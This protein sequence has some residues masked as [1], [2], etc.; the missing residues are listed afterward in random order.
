MNEKRIISSLNILVITGYQDQGI[1]PSLINIVG[2]VYFDRLWKDGS[3]LFAF[4][5]YHTLLL[6]R[7][8]CMSVFDV[9]LCVRD[10]AKFTERSPGIDLGADTFFLPRPQINVFCL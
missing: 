1:P 3:N 4:V 9:A 8:I 2:N 6:Y 7:L 5:L 10:E